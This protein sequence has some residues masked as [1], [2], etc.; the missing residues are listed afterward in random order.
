MRV[1]YKQII[2]FSLHFLVFLVYLSPSIFNGYPILMADSG[3]YL[4]SGQTGVVPIDRPIIYGLFI[5]HISLSW[6]VWL[7][8][9]FQVL[10]VNY[11]L[12]LLT[13]YAL[14]VK[15]YTTVTYAVIS[16]VLFVLTGISYHAN[17][18]IAD[19]FTS[20]SIIYFFMILILPKK[21]FFHFGMSILIFC[22]AI[23]THL[24]HILLISA[25]A[26]ALI[27]IVYFYKKHYLRRLGITIGCIAISLLTMAT[28]N[29]SHGAGFKLSR[30]KYVVLSGRLMESGILENYLNEKC[31]LPGKKYREL[32]NYKDQFNKWPSAGAYLWTDTSPI[33]SGNCDSLSFVNCWFE[34][35]PQYKELFNDIIAIPKYRND[36]IALSISGILKQMVIFDQSK[37]DPVN[38]DGIIEHY[39]SYDFEGYKASKQR[40]QTLTFLRA[41]TIEAIT[42][43][44][45]VIM[46]LLLVLYYRKSL[47]FETKMFVLIVFLGLMINAAI[48]ATLSNFVPRYQGRI[49]FLVPFALMYVGIDCFRMKNFGD[50]VNLKKLLK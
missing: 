49:I 34:K 14:K 9:I 21:K 28:I 16:M 48:C 40:K 24:S 11:A 43:D 36:L 37:L 38:V 18:L 50:K 20:L 5:R 4:A 46:L 6:S 42:F 8:L 15:K 26:G 19:I 39:Y 2:S 17:L 22:F 3:T 1:S 7:P 29:Y 33:Y 12:Y 47:S 44:I 32:C 30:I 45:S 10:F 31:P 23:I 41:S 27:L 13:K 35:E 25:I